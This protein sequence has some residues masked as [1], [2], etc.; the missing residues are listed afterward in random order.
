MS[1]P[2]VNRVRVRTPE[3][4]LFSYPLAGPVTRFLAWIVDVTAIS[5]AGSLVGSFLAAFRLL[6]PDIV[7]ALVVFGYFALSM[8]YGMMFEWM[9]RGQTLGKK[10]LRLRVMDEGGLPLRFSQVVLRNL[11]RAVDVLPV[12]YLVGG[13]VMSLS[14]RA[15]R[16]GDIAAGT[17][18]VRHRQRREPDFGQL[19]E[20]KHNSLRDHAHL[21]A[22]LRQQV[23]P[24]LAAAAV[25]ALLR[26]DLLDPEARVQLFEALAAELQKLVP[27]PPEVTV[28]MP[29]EAYVRNVVEIVQGVTA[30]RPDRAPAPAPAAIAQR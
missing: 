5:V 20:G 29:A 4:V 16:L 28:G 6:S 14:P 2:R 9:W 7:Q 30:G 19:F 18:V 27:Y 17:I 15:Q 24:E 3:G 22:R 13:A 25:G 1:E 26:R 23:S 12:A 8:G 21:A 11:L 10:L